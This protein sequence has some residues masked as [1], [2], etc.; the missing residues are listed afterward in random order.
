LEDFFEIIGLFS[1][2]ASYLTG[3]DDPAQYL[4]DFRD[5]DWGCGAGVSGIWIG[6]DTGG[7]FTDLVLADIGAR[8]YAY[9]KLPTSTDDPAR[10]ILE[11]VTALLAAAGAA[12]G[13]ATYL[14][15][16]TTL[17]TNAV[18]EG[19]YAPT[20]MITT[21]G[22]RD[23]LE[24]AR[25]RRPSF[26]NLDVPKPQAP[27]RRDAILEVD[28]RLD[29]RGNAVAPLDEA[30]VTDAAAV[31]RAKG[32]QAVAVCFLH[33]YAN[34]DHEARCKALIQSVW[35]E[36]YVSTSAE[37][38]REFREYERFA[39]ACM[40]ASLMP[41]VDRYLAR[42][43]SGLHELGIPCRPLVMQSNGGAV[44]CGAVRQVPVNTFFSGPA[45]GVIATAELGRRLGVADLI[46]FD[47]GGTS[48][49]VC[50]IRDGA[51][52][53]RASR[54]IGGL[55]ARIA[56]LDIH[57][58]GAG[59][60]SLAW[61][62]SGGLMKVGPQS[63]GAFPGPAFYGR[64]GEQATVTDANAVLGRLAGGALLGGRMQ[65]YPEKAAAAVARLGVALS[66]D[67]TATAA[68]IVEIVNV[69]MMGAV[70]VVS[71]ERGEDPRDCA[72]V[73]FGGAGP[74]HAA[75]VAAELGMRRVVVP[76]HPGLLS[77][78][79][80]LDADVRGDFALT[81]LVPA[82]AAGIDALNRSRGDLLRR[83]DTWRSEEHLAEDD[84]RRA[85]HAD[86]RY[87][88]QSFE[89]GVELPDADW[90]AADIAAAVAAFHQRH[91]AVNG[92]AMPDHPVEVVNLRG[93]VIAARPLAPAEAPASA[94]GM[95]DVT[96]R[97]VW[98]RE[99]GF[100]ETPIHRRADFAVGD[101]IEGPA[102]VEQMDST[103]VIPPGWHAVVA[104]EGSLLME[105]DA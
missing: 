58:I 99:T 59:G 16:G 26:F 19:K 33:A 96:V 91:E 3:R 72:L 85:W 30:G 79:G 73:A 14:A 47:M 63:A 67:N 60:G 104:V 92:Y 89:L 49:D 69:N 27:A 4:R 90:A 20:G 77:A 100:V 94:S 15:H 50:L 18:L 66:L 37:V 17:A 28:E 25:Q 74:L 54:E 105:H 2:E 24:I 7:T 83:A 76:P 95:R 71:V 51:P 22:F 86:L 56:T 5:M 32:V 6:I 65:A 61:V 62:D 21:R 70:R 35:P 13:D 102:I 64:G 34:P 57:T 43:E 78:Q 31:L 97:P 48:T 68:G 55:P 9:Y 12:P 11:G 81:C 38:S 36:A 42:F 40:N 45:G 101:R 87:A 8:R 88:G 53:R 93:A 44:S 29:E 39:T 75:E 52:R 10:A 1:G 80:L 23:I 98:F 46:S 82:D 103:T 41:V 84:I